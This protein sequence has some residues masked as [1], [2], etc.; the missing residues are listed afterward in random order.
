MTKTA[1]GKLLFYPHNPEKIEISYKK[2]LFFDEKRL[3]FLL[4]GC[5]LLFQFF[6]NLLHITHKS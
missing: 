6:E 5:I 1:F 4:P 3:I 2:V